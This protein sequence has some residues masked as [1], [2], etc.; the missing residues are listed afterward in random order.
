VTS[1]PE[2]RYATTEDGVS[3]AFQTVG[4]GPVDL[5]FELEGWGNVEVM[6]ELPQLAELFERLSQFSRLV[7]HDRRG[8]G[9]SGGD[10]SFPNLETRARDLLTV[11][12][13]IRSGRVALFGNRTAGAALALFAV[14]YPDRVASLVWFQAVAT[15]RWSPEYPWGMTPD[16]HRRDA[17]SN[18]DMLGNTALQREWLESAAPPL[19]G[20][21][22]LAARIARLDRHFMAPST[23]VNWMNAESETDVRAVLP[24]LR[25]A[26][27]VLDHK[28]SPSKAAE[29]RHV[30]GLIPGAELALVSGDAYVLP[31]DNLAGIAEAVRQFVSREPVTESADT[32]LATVLFTDIVGSTELQATMGDSAW[33]ELVGRHHAIV[34]DALEQWR[35]VENDTAGDGFYATFDGPARAIRCAVDIVRR[36]RD[37]ELEIRAGL[38]TG[39]CKI[40]DGKHGGL[41][42]TIGSRI[43]AAS[44]A[45]EV[46]VSRTVKDLTA[47]SGFAFEDRG[48][49][50]LKGVPERWQLYRVIA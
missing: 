12:D 33:V 40:V 9:L 43:A 1:I 42:V 3:L 49:H 32:V 34:R 4:D 15:R 11:L 21:E 31:F 46:L 8:T 36:M 28:A 19:A 48:E 41:T 44:C 39:E 6:W 26:T 25:C 5:V 24:L 23:V 30:Q 35:G 38:H 13:S 18:R 20:D 17:A 10:P 16:E 50:E 2:T 22:Q 14:T 29:S 27:L 7:L 37:I 45:S 47:G